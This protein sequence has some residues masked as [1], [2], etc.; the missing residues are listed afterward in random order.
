MTELSQARRLAV[1]TALL[2]Q[3]RIA[4]VLGAPLPTWL[5][6]RLN[7]LQNT[8]NLVQVAFNVWTAYFGVPILASLIYGTIA[9][10]VWI[11]TNSLIMTG[12]VLS[13][14]GMI[15]YGI[16][17]ELQYPSFL[18]IVFGVAAVIYRLAKR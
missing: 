3:L 14:L 11:E 16:L 15:L 12:I 5:Q 8:W 18:A 4:G 2:S 1:A 9:M 13:T 6:D 17:P 7:E 10:I